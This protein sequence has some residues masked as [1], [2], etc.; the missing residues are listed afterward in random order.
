M[1]IIIFRTRIVNKDHKMRI[2]LSTIVLYEILIEAEETSDVHTKTG[3][4]S[5]SG[6]ILLYIEI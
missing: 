1:L 5:A 3:T 6:D 4:T 2:S